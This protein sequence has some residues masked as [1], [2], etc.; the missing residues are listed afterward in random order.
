MFNLVVKL[1]RIK[2]SAKW[3]KNHLKKTM[4]DDDIEKKRCQPLLNF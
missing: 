2:K 4:L 3:I 1:K